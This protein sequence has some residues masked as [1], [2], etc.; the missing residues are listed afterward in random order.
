MNGVE[1]AMML[2]KLYNKSF[3]YKLNSFEEDIIAKDAYFSFLYAKN[4]LKRPFKKGEPEICKYSTYAIMYAR[5]FNMPLPEAEEIISKDGF[6][7]YE[8]ATKVLK[9]RFLLGE[10]QILNHSIYRNL[11]LNVFDID[12]FKYKIKVVRGNGNFAACLLV[13][14]NIEK[15]DI[16][17]LGWSTNLKDIKDE[18]IKQLNL[19]YPNWELN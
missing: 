1:K 17:H 18:A 9:R 6:D 5:H 14:V 3:N 2:Q 7:S 16:I 12:D 8:Y 19:N 13:K 10:P 15:I 11:Y 4:V